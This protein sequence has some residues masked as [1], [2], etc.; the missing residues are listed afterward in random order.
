M[1]GIQAII[2]AIIGGTLVFPSDWSDFKQVSLF[3]LVLVGVFFGVKFAMV[4]KDR[5]VTGGTVQQPRMV[6]R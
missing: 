3:A 4:A 1:G 6:A 2:T 5:S